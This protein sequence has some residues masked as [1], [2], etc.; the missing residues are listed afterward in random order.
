MYGAV[1]ILSRTYGGSATVSFWVHALKLVS[2]TRVIRRRRSATLSGVLDLLF[3]PFVA[4]IARPYLA[5]VVAAVFMWAYYWSRR[6]VVLTA[7]VTW[8]LYGIFEYGNYLRITCHG[9]C[10]IRVDMLLIA[11]IL[12]ALTIGASVSAFRAIVMAPPRGRRHKR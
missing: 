6:G 5:L 3:L 11:P 4:V 2:P 8:F 12:A 10:N 7:A 1:P 9:E